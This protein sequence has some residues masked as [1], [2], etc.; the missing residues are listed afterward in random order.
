MN[1]I[2]T[3]NI[4]QIETL[5]KKHKVEERYVSGLV[6]DEKK[7]ITNSDVNLLVNFDKSKISEKGFADNFFDLADEL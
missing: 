5:F 3:K 1:A 6:T 4:S 2:I 7:I